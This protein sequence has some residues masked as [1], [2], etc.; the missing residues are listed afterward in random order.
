MFQPGGGVSQAARRSNVAGLI[1]P[2]VECHPSPVI[3]HFD[4]IEQRHPRVPVA[5]EVLAE[6][7]LDRREEALHDG[8]G[9]SRQLHRRRAV[10]PKSFASRIPST[11]CMAA[12]S[13]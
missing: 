6:L 11:P 4:V 2:S 8:I 7:A 12:S 3:Q 13:N 9:V 5:V 1:W 10:R